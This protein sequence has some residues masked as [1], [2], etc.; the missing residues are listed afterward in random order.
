M[1]RWLPAAMVA[2]T[3]VSALLHAVVVKAGVFAVVKVTVY[4][5]GIDTLSR[6]G[7]AD[8]LLYMA[9]FTIVCASFIAAF[10]DNLKRR[11]AYS[12]ISQLSYI[13]MGAAMFTPWGIFRDAHCCACLWQDHLF[14]AAGSIYTAAHKTKIRNWMVSV[15]NAVDHGGLYGWQF[16]DD[17]LAA[18]GWDGL[19]MVS[20]EWCIDHSVGFRDY[21]VDLMTLLNA[22]YLPII[23][24]FFQ[25]EAAPG[26]MTVMATMRMIT[27]TPWPIVFA[28]T[29]T[30]TATAMFFFTPDLF[31]AVMHAVHNGTGQGQ[32]WRQPCLSK[33]HQ[34][35]DTMSIDLQHR[36]CRTKQ[37]AHSVGR[38][39]GMVA[40]VLLVMTLVLWR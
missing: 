5:F 39:L 17:R 31:Q 36:R 19:Q 32:S 1:Q 7:W 11:L 13:I 14:F 24:A 3:P 23:Y 25:D 22:C 27:L 26:M 10:Q 38:Q 33:S 35:G 29:C 40:L 37:L 30:A 15:A 6:I 4:I 8:W 18:D 9:G 20:V 2:P 21:R 28:L 12:T 16:V 34:E